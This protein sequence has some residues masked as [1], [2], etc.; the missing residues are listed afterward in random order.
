VHNEFRLA[1]GVSVPTLIGSGITAANINDFPDPSK[2]IESFIA[3]ETD[4]D[5]LL[6]H[7]QIKKN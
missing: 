6:R 4:S 3:A 7:L 2:G 1:K 5:F